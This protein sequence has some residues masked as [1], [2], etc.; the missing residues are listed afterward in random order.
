MTKNF[1]NDNLSNISEEDFNSTL[2]AYLDTDKLDEAHKYVYEEFS[3]GVAHL[4]TDYSMGNTEKL[5]TDKMANLFNHLT[6]Y[7]VTYDQLVK[8]ISEL[9]CTLGVKS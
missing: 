6:S 3:K 5:S 8:N 2:N 7:K 4:L 1:T 9:I